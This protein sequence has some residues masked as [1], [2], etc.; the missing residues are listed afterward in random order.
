MITEEIELN[1]D[2]LLAACTKDDVYKYMTRKTPLSLF[3]AKLCA[4]KA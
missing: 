4:D 3:E 2:C 1:I